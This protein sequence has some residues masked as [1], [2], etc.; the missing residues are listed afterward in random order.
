MNQKYQMSQQTVISGVSEMKYSM[1]WQIIIIPNDVFM[2]H[3]TPTSTVVAFVAFCYLL[4]ASVSSTP[5]HLL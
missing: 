3:I 5:K 2:V 1:L 4:G